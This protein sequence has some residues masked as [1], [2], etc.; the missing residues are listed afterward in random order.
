[1]K[2]NCYKYGFIERYTKENQSI[3]GYTKEE[4][5]YRYVGKEVAKYIYD[6]SI[7]YEEYYA[8]FLETN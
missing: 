7:T 8:T 1:M 5:H 4:W 2:S 6:N 3:T